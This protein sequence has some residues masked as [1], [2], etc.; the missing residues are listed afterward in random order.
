MTGLQ[1]D[2]PAPETRPDPAQAAAVYAHRVCAAHH[3]VE[4][5]LPNVP[6]QSVYTWLCAAWLAGYQQGQETMRNLAALTAQTAGVTTTTL[7]Q[8][9]IVTTT[10]LDREAIAQA[11]RA[12]PL[13]AEAP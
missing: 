4:P 7:R 8:G 12:L 11:I 2:V 9:N 1:P 10:R 13:T 3:T 5:N 6:I